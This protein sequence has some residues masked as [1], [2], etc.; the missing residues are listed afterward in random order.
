[1]VVRSGFEI[2]RSPYLLHGRGLVAFL[3]ILATF[4]FIAIAVY[5]STHVYPNSQFADK[6]A[7]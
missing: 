2:F 4:R 6:E 7:N 5:A 3:F 1:M